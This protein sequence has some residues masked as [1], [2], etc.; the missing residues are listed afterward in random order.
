MSIVAEIYVRIAVK[1]SRTHPRRSPAL[2]NAKGKLNVP[3]PMMFDTK[4][5]ALEGEDAWRTRP[6]DGGGTGYNGL[7]CRNVSDIVPSHSS[8]AGQYLG[9]TNKGLQYS[10]LPASQVSRMAINSAKV[11]KA[12]SD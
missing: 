2:R 12:G 1:R 9:L 11:G 10:S 7:W 4:L 8:W 3:T 5:K 6:G